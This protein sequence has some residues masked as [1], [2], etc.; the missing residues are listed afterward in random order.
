MVTQ[1]EKLIALEQI[2]E[3]NGGVLT[4]EAVL[5]ASR[6]PEA[7]LHGLFEWNDDAAAEQYRLWQA[8][9][10]IR[11]VRITV[12]RSEGSTQ[13]RVYVNLKDDGQA[14]AYHRVVD[15]VRNPETRAQMVEQVWRELSAMKARYR[16][17]MQQAEDSR[18]QTI[19]N[20]I[21]QQEIE[22]TA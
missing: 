4:P 14:Q 22:E 19:Y 17:L 2:R 8:R 3:L 6:E 5:A 21:Q 15:V 12:N 13:H 11:S 1:R 20:L 16:D 10:L 9:C 18:L 7:P